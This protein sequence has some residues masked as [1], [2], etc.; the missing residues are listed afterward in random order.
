[1]EKENT[2]QLREESI[3]PDDAV[4]ADILGD[5]FTAYQALIKLFDENQLS[6]QWRYYKD[7][8]AWL[9]KVQKKDKTIVWMSAW[10]GFVKATI[11]IPEK[12]IDQVFALEISEDR[13]EYFRQSKN[14]GKSRACTF[15]IKSD[16]VLDDFN[17]VMQVKFTIK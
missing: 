12:Y 10:K 11:Y 9:C 5:S 3:F 13:K 6:H 8:K 15:E 7:G 2:I 14:M 16:E 17:K 1:M 4:L